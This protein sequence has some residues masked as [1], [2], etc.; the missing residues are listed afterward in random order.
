[1]KSNYKYFATLFHKHRF[2]KYNKRYDTPSLA[3]AS[4][5]GVVP[6]DSGALPQIIQL[7]INCTVEIVLMKSFFLHALSTKA[8]FLL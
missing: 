6:S 8:Q 4:G 1:M 3:S 5:A 2:N 7:H